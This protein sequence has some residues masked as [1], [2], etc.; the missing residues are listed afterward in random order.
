MER[1]RLIPKVKD[2][3]SYVLKPNVYDDKSHQWSLLHQAIDKMT[4]EELFSVYN[5]CIG[6]GFATIDLFAKFKNIS[7]KGGG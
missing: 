7:S 2:V 3:L 5:L 1:E 6:K 4:N